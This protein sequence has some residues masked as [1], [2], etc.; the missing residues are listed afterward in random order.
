MTDE[1]L[2]KRSAS[3]K[4][5]FVVSAGI[6]AGVTLAIVTVAIVAFWYTSRPVK[7]GAWDRTAIMAQYTGLSVKTS[8]PLVF[9]FRYSV[10]NHT[11]LDYNFPTPTNIYK[12]L[13]EGKGLERDESLRWGDA[14]S[15]PA[16]QKINIAIQIEYE[17]REASEGDRNDPEKLTEFVKRRLAEIEGFAALDEAKRYEITF[18]K[19][20]DA[21]P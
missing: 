17:F 3:V 12:I 2:I 15:L 9:T 18:P 7:P 5:L 13:P 4:R 16:G 11:G 21:K 1:S 10:E 6:A 14:T 19:P 8:D 20:P